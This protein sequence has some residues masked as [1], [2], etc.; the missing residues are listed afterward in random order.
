[1][2][3]GEIGDELQELHQRAHAAP[4]AHQQALA[5]WQLGGQRG[6]RPESERPK[7]EGRIKGLQADYEAVTIAIGRTLDDKVAYVEGTADG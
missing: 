7:L 2:R 5:E 1:M 4:A 6:P 3:Q